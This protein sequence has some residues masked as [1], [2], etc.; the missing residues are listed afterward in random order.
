[1]IERDDGR[2][3]SQAVALDDDEAESLPEILQR[4]SQWRR[5]DDERPEL[6]AEHAMDAP[7]AP[8]A[9]RNRQAWWRV[10]RGGIDAQ[11]VLLQDVED[12]RHADDHRDLPLAH[13]PHDVVR[14]EAAHED[15]RSVDERRNVR[16]HRLSEE[17]AERQQVQES[18]RL[19]GPRVPLVFVDL[20][21]HRHDVGEDVAMTD[22]HAFRFGCRARR[23]HDLRHVIAI[24]RHDGYRTVGRPVKSCQPP[25]VTVYVGSIRLMADQQDACI[26]DRRMRSANSRDDRKSIGTAIAP[27][28]WIPQ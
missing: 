25:D 4:R 2:R 1:M 3:F 23:E 7:V 17:V 11:R 14:V 18:D 24:D 19:K 9:R 5:P 27:A 10:G 22:H 21:R 8:P 26:N 20:A 13:A 15:H 28:S 16:G 12:L 6:Q